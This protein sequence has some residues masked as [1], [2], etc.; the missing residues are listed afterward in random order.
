MFE[1][2]FYDQIDQELLANVK[3]KNDWIVDENDVIRFRWKSKNFDQAIS[4]L[5][6]AQRCFKKEIHDRIDESL[7]DAF[8]FYLY[9]NCS[10]FWL[11]DA[12]SLYRFENRESFLH[13]ELKIS[14]SLRF[15]HEI[16]HLIV[17]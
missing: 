11:N 5:I 16:F 7:N 6:T 4:W 1:N 13:F 8:F 17:L 14:N 3:S 15:E 9:E 10:S 2:L 12:R